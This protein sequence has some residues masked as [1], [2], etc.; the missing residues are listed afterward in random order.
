M[1]DPS[2]WTDEKLGECTRDER[3]LFMGLISNA[4][5]E[6]YGRAN[7]KL[8]RSSIFPYDDLR[9]SDLDKWLSRLGGF[10]L[11][12]LYQ[13]KGQTYYYLPNFSRYQTINR[14]T[15]SSI[16]K[17]DE[18][19]KDTLTEDSLSAH[20]GLTEDSRLKEI[21]EK[22]R[23]K[24]D[25]SSG[26][27]AS[28]PVD[29]QSIVEAFNSI[30]ASLP[31]V[32]G[33]SDQRRKAIRKAVKQ[34]ED[35][36]ALFKKVEA[37]D[38]LTGRSGNWNGCGFDWI[39]KPANLTKILEG[40]YDNR[41]EEPDIPTVYAY[42]QPEDDHPVEIPDGADLADILPPAEEVAPW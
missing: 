22:R 17:P 4:D 34:V 2:F 6:G 1:I 33:L 41:Q 30:C 39:L 20:G 19:S 13:V 18:D 16:P 8:L 42:P 14:P 29:V 11:I 36:P 27:D 10:G 37:S 21:E 3:L 32:R 15:P 35:F 25:M 12:A 26:D 7:P 38:F 24:K 28:A 9:V 31:K 5:D 23:E 40:N